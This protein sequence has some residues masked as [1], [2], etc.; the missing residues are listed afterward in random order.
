MY[1]DGTPMEDTGRSDNVESV[2]VILLQV[3][4]NSSTIDG[5]SMQQQWVFVVVVVVVCLF[6]VFV[7]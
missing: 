7:F 1:F 2:Q 3:S 4:Y 6:F 5:L